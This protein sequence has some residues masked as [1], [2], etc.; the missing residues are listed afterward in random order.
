MDKSKNFRID[1]LLADESHRGNRDTSPGLDHGSLT[2]SPTTCQKPDSRFIIP[3]LDLFVM[4]PELASLSHGTIPGMYTAPL[5]PISLPGCQHQAFNYPGSPHFTHP[6]PESPKTAALP[7]EQWIQAGIMV[8]S[9]PGYRSAPPSVLLGKCRRPRTAFTS[10][11]LL[12]LENQF[13]LNKYLSRPKRFEVAT[14]LMLTETQ[15][16]IWFQNRRMKWKRSRRSSGR[17]SHTHSEGPPG[18]EHPGDTQPM[19]DVDGNTLEEDVDD[20]EEDKDEQQDFVL[21]LGKNCHNPSDY[22]QCAS[23]RRACS[24]ADLEETKK[25]RQGQDLCG[26]L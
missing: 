4:H 18:C 12:E 1:A 9:P 26:D 19:D 23:K 13:K 6:H 8:P 10:Q 22:L 14:S 11:Q 24:D 3:K 21:A 20:T 2:G 16:K 15:V 25:G 5:Y 7:I 17:S